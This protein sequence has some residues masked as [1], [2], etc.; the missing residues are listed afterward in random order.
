MTASVVEVL[1][2]GVHVQILNWHISLINV[3]N[4]NF[5]APTAA[6]ASVSTVNGHITCS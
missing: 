1:V 6:A 2:D 3:K 5:T 4:D